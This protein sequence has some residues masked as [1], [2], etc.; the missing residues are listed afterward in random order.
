MYFLPVN[1]EV[2]MDVIKRERPDGIILSMGGQSALN[3]GIELYNSG[4]LEKYGVRVL[5]TPVST[6]IKTED[7]EI[8]GN[9]MT[10]RYTES[11]GFSIPYM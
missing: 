10:V 1:F 7:R 11:I 2:V 9:M 8:F 5:G 6:I 4:E 3:V